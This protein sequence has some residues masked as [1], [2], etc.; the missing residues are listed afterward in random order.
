MK[1]IVGNAV[2]ELCI[3]NI[4]CFFNID[5]RVCNFNQERESLLNSG[6]VVFGINIIHHSN[7]NYNGC[8][9]SNACYLISTEVTTDP[10]N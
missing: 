8:S 5:D 4:F 9:K 3:V 10:G 1:L 6:S 7:L 2:K